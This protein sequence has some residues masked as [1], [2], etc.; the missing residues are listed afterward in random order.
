MTPGPACPRVDYRGYFQFLAQLNL[1]Y[2]TTVGPTP[3]PI[4]RMPRHIT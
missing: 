1:I 2:S 4:Y 3:R